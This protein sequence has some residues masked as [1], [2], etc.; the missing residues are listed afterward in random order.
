MQ[1]SGST[2]GW[3]RFPWR[4]AWLSTPGF[5]PGKSHGQ[6]SLAGYR[7]W[8]RKESDTTEPL[9][10]RGRCSEDSQLLDRLSA[11]ENT[12]SDQRGDEG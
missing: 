7:P 9:S 1:D 6:R 12:G 4:R 2:P 8:G 3:R 11:S 5:L 10:T